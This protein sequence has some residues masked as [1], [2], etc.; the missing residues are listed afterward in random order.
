MTECW[1]S[2]LGLCDEKTSREHLVSEGLFVD[3]IVRV[4]GFSW[5]R[6]NP[7]EIGLNSLTAKILCK[8]HN[9]ALSP[10]DEV[11]IA[12]FGAFREMRRV[13]N[14]REKMRPRVWHVI[15]HSIDGLML[16]RWFLKTL[17]NLSLNGDYPIGGMCSKGSP[18]E[19][20]VKIA[21]GITPFPGRAGLY[22]VV[23]IGGNIY[24]SDTIEFTPLINK[25]NVFIVGGL[26]SFRGFK[27]L[28]FLLPEGPPEQLIGIR[29]GGEDWGQ[30][31]LNYHN[32]QF[33]EI[34]GTHLSQIVNCKW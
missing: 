9:E 25:E 21:F 14:E 20:L 10:V 33:K 28:L 7:K 24:S 30:S 19:N 12:A 26:F 13:A 16:E 11:G 23:H 8:K 1:A 3:P 18:T 32:R 22:S 15:H 29:V 6:G 2:K 31:Q 34:L 4:E 17:I 27:F 5:C